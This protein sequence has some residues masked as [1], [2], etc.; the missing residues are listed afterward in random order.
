MAVNRDHIDACRSKARLIAVHLND[1]ADRHSTLAIEQA[2]LR[3]VGAA[4]ATHHPIIVPIAHKLGMQALKLGVAG[5][6]GRVMIARKLSA[7][8][9]AEYLAKHGLGKRDELDEVSWNQAQRVVRDAV[10]KWTQF[11]PKNPNGRLRNGQFRTAVTISTGSVGDDL[12]QLKECRPKT[13]LEI[14]TLPTASHSD[15]MAV[16]HRSLF[17]RKGYPILEAMR[18]AMHFPGTAEVCWQGRV[19]PETLVA[20]GHLSHLRLGTD[21]MAAIHS[22]HVDPRKAFVDYGFMLRLATRMGFRLQTDQTRWGTSALFETHAHQWLSM[23]IVLEQWVMQCGGSL[24]RQAVV[25]P[26]A[27]GSEKIPDLIPELARKQLYREFFPQAELWQ[28]VL[29][30]HA[31]LNVAMSAMMDFSGAVLQF[32]DMPSAESMKQWALALKP[33]AYECQ[34]SD[35][36]QISRLMHTLLERTMKELNHLHHNQSNLLVADKLAQGTATVFEK[37][38]RYWNPLDDF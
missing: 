9:A 18:K 10:E 27:A 15:G 17:R 22:E 37:D 5:W 26:D 24:E 21:P 33:L 30:S 12:S 31:T 20:A 11:I 34:F 4:S 8:K 1:L 36:G 6:L 14:V 38:R 25:V 16:E 2:V 13:D 7:E 29:H 3:A 35:H 32:Q 23:Q 28:Q 19:V